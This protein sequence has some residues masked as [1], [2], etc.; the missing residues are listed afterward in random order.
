MTLKNTVR[1]VT[2]YFLQQQEINVR[3]SVFRHVVKDGMAKKNIKYFS[4]GGQN[5]IRQR[6]VQKPKHGDSC[7]YC[8]KQATQIDHVIPKNMLR[9]FALSTEPI[10]LENIARRV[11]MVFSC[12]ECNRLL[13]DTF[14]ESLTEKKKLLKSRLKRRHKKLLEIPDWSPNEIEELGYNLRSYVQNSLDR[15]FLL[16]E[17]LRW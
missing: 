17:R 15:L 4:N 12:G 8:G 11:L 2:G 13:S 16:K 7:Y 14:T 6:R 1:N 9:N 10:T 3:Y 5:M